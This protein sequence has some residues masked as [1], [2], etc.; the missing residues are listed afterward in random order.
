M[1]EVPQLCISTCMAREQPPFANS[2]NATGSDFCLPL[3]PYDECVGIILFFF[4]STAKTLVIYREY[5][6]FLTLFS[7][8]ISIFMILLHTFS[9]GVITDARLPRSERFASII[10][11]CVLLRPP[12]ST[13]VLEPFKNGRSLWV[14]KVN[15]L[16][17]LKRRGGWKRSREFRVKL[18]GIPINWRMHAGSALEDADVSS[19]WR[20]L[21]RLR[22]ED[23]LEIL[24]RAVVRLDKV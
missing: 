20:R 23:E 12:V 18:K 2:G 9:R 22:L 21:W 3:I 1:R 5:W 6:Y 16:V 4:D 10:R 15:E 13:G 7:Q 24:Y 14:A 11:S 19:L 8:L 17:M